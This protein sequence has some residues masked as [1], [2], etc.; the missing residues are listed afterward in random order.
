MKILVILYIITL[1]F[2][3]LHSQETT[4]ESNKYGVFFG[5]NPN[6][7]SAKFNKLPG[8]PNCCPE[9]ESGFGLGWNVGVLY[10]R[11]VAEKLWIGTRLGM[12][13]LD[14][15]LIKE[16][17]TTVNVANGSQAGSFEHRVETKFSNFGIE[18]NL[19]YEISD[20]LFINI[21]PRIDFNLTSTFS[22][23]ET[24]KNPAGFGT[25]LDENGNDT[26]SRIRNQAAGDIDKATSIFVGMV[27][28]IAYELP[29]N[30]SN[31]FR[32][33]P[34][35]S[36][37]H[38]FSDFT[39]ETQWTNTSLRAIVAV[40]YVQQKSVEKIKI[41]REEFLKDTLFVQVSGEIAQSYKMGLEFSTIEKLD[42]GK[43]I[44]ETTVRTRTDTVFTT[45]KYALS[46]NLIAVGIDENGN[47]VENPTFKIEEF[48]SNRLDPLLNYI[49]FDENSAAIPNRYITKD[50]RQAKQFNLNS[51]FY[52]SNIEIY[53]NLMN[54]IGLRMNE[55]T[56]T[57]ITLVGCNS[58]MN[59]ERNNLELSR[60]RANA[61]KDYLVKNWQIDPKR[62]KIDAKN[63][64]QKASLPKEET[65]KIAENRRV[66]IYSDNESILAPIFIEKIDRSSN[67]P[68]VRFKPQINSEAGLQTWK[69]EAYQKTDVSNMFSKQ[70]ENTLPE[71]ID[72]ELAEFQKI[73]P[74]LPEDLIYI[75]KVND[76]AN[77]LFTTEEQALSVDILSLQEKRKEKIDD[78]EIERF[79]LILFDFDKSNIED[80]NSK[81]IDLIKSRI[82]TNSKIEIFGYTDRTGNPE[83]NLKLS[84]RRANATKDAL[85]RNDA[86]ATGFGQDKLLYDNT[87][88]EGR[89]YCRTIE[90]VIKTKVD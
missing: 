18:P 37:Y 7:H 15:N 6:F 84:E 88:P 11:K 76:R 39:S 8:V 89:F 83:Y 27:A 2:G 13:T 41:Q 20:N 38:S 26:Q 32:M 58:D 47:E 35:L 87:F 54:I 19:L 68:I 43:Q 31:T 61:V 10:E 80:K 70:G 49:F 73:I 53:Y 82:K 52:D 33:V 59:D 45:K 16:E 42:D 60:K 48:V 4:P 71:I 63:L 64:P 55:N 24:I 67:P 66:E 77:N 1:S 79:S 36:L 28:G 74:K 12:Q 75:L 9:F 40:K 44:V 72:W 17:A 46:G 22:Q 30:K 34:E 23:A 21:G 85:R 90:V 5:L 3:Y 29:L 56:G 65:D 25:F 86:I 81:I 69:I 57:N 14:A 62:I 51:L 78:Y 50:A